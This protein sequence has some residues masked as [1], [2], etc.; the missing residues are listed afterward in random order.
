MT[1]LAE[2]TA[3]NAEASTNVYTERQ[4]RVHFDND[5]AEVLQAHHN[6]PKCRCRKM[7]HMSRGYWLPITFPP[8]FSTFFLS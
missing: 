2:H 4:S 7:T 1:L 8:L 3:G 5:S 6:D